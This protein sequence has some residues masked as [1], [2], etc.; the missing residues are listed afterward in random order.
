MPGAPK[1]AFQYRPRS[2]NIFLCP[3]VSLLEFSNGH[4][5][6]FEDYVTHI[7]MR[8]VM[9]KNPPFLLQPALEGS[10]RKGRENRKGGKFD[11]IPLDKFNRFSKDARIIP[12]ETED[13]GTVDADSMALNGPR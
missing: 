2:A 7:I 10:S 11:I 9:V 1:K 6:R 12:I 13:E 8:P 5:F 3:E 4:L